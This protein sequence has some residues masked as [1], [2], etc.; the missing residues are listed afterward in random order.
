MAYKT[1]QE[2]FWAG[3][4]GNEY[5]AR[6]AG[7]DRVSSNVAAFSRILSSAPGVGSLVELGCNAGLN[8]Q[9]LNR[10]NNGLELCGYE[11]NKEAAQKARDL[12][13]AKIVEGTILDPLSSDEQYDLSFTKGVLIHINPDELDKVY[14]NLYNLSKRYI[15]VCEYYNPTPVV[16]EYRGN[17][18]RLFKRDFAGD[19]ID[20]YGLRLVDYGFLYHRDNCFPQDDI[21]WFLLE[22]KQL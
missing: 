18:D 15:L 11:I 3:E 6:N 8:L 13:V 17:H 12:D 2:E 22:K 9:A 5:V 4:F 21:S 1:Q 16:V 19:L 10:I 14:S 20:K 7:E